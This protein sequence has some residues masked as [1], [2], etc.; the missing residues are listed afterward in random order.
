MKESEVGDNEQ[1]FLPRKRKY[2]EG[3]WM[4]LGQTEHQG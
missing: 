3:S 4:L 1:T 2:E